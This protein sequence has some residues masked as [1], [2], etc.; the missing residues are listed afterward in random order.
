VLLLEIAVQGVRGVSP[1]GGRL[2]LR[3][4][5]NVLAVEG[6]PFR[7][8]LEAL[9]WPSPRDGEALQR[10]APGQAGAPVR[11]GITLVGNDQVT[12]RL[13]RDFAAGSQLL[14][15]DGE[16]RSFSPVSQDLAEIAACLKAAGVPS[17]DLF[18]A[19]L[20]LA[21]AEIPSRGGAP[22]L[23]GAGPGMPAR[24]AVRPAE[25]HK[26]AGELRVELE[27]ARKSEK[28]QYRLDGLQS[29]LFKLEEAL[30]EGAR[31]REGLERSDAEVGEMGAVARVADRLGDVEA[32]LAAH[33]R[34]GTRRDEGLARVADERQALEEI[35][36]RGTPQALWQQPAFLASAGA[37]LLLLALGIAGAAQGSP[38][39]Y[40]GLL[41]LFA[42]GAAAWVA[43][44]H[45]DRVEDLGRV[46]RRRKVIE[47]RERKLAQHWE[48][49]GA[50]VR[51]ALAELGAAGPAELQERLRK[52]A[53]VRSAQAE[54][55]QKLD[56]WESQP[57]TRGA[58]EERA[59]VEAE[60]RE[61]EADLSSVA[62]GYVRDPR[63][64]ES[65]ISRLEQ[66]AASP[67]APEVDLPAAPAAPQLEPI[68]GLL[69][70]AAAALGQ[71]PSGVARA[72]QA[73]ASQL[74]AA[75][76]AQRL[77]GLSVDDRGN[78]SVL[79]GGRPQAALTL[80]PADRDLCFLA[81]RL[82]LLEQG[83]AGGRAVA[84]LDDAF[85]GA[86]DG[87][88]RAAARLLKQAARA[89]QVLHGTRDPAFREAADHSA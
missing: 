44:R 59:R 34:A 23:A 67:E 81:L 35:A 62:G 76:S 18:D 28:L 70:R 39:R 77:A 24:P 17:R 21:A 60:M 49:D 82:A 30:R 40:L 38:V 9:L 22:R 10:A 12:Y 36:G 69:D 48:R 50:E 26:R 87:V 13:V 56:A 42:F 33:A 79:I 15:F 65:E 25:A 84:F 32:V 66:E 16:K 11:A 7:R 83:L 37:G 58:R 19:V 55:R 89:G 43:L 78:P 41:D 29:Q 80:P 3:P 64:I 31:I 45:V 47:E 72:L 53:D 68:R 61:A 85:A 6:A 71:T 54:W 4:G 86:S 14:R 73:R 63:S 2:A 74:V 5:Y 27:R 8:L 75:L 52:L 46:E 57:E 51:A 1:A 88:R 20:S